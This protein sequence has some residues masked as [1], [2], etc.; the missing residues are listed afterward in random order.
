MK[1]LTMAER[2][3]KEN[4]IK[5]LEDQIEKLAAQS[6]LYTG[7]DGTFLT[8]L[9]W[10][11]NSEKSGDA[12]VRAA[13]DAA[14]D[15]QAALHVEIGKLTTKKSKIEKDLFGWSKMAQLFLDGKQTVNV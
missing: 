12:A 6:K 11:A 15:A 3:E 5:A 2:V 4:E 7:T 9:A 10:R 8:S 1:V 14:W 13:A